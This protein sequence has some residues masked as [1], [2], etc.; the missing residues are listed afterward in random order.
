MSY[1][2]DSLKKL[3]QE[4]LEQSPK[5]DIKSILLK[6]EH[7][8]KEI[9]ELRSKVKVLLAFSLGL[10][11]LA[12]FL[13]IAYYGNSSRENMDSGEKEEKVGPAE[14]TTEMPEIKKAQTTEKKN[15]FSSMEKPGP[16]KPPEDQFVALT[17]DTA[18]QIQEKI[19]EGPVDESLL[20]DN[21]APGFEE[22]A[23]LKETIPQHPPGKTNKS[24]FPEVEIKTV[25]FFGQKNPDNYIILRDGANDRIKLQ[26]GEKYME[27]ELIEIL[28]R[29]ARFVLEGDLFE[30]EMGK[31]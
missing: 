1:I 18:G 9:A 8:E 4:K 16:R 22:T 2:L 20:P 13:G 28:P 30:K 3:E 14:K 19:E 31:E 5:S 27:A 24:L 29:K 6:T 25:V 15:F 7:S 23:L 21:A 12:I 17:E 26:E 10:C 11:A